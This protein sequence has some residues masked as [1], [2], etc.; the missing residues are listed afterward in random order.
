MRGYAANGLPKDGI[1]IYFYGMCKERTAF[2]GLFIQW[3]VYFQH[4]GA[5]IWELY[6]VDKIRCRNSVELE[7]NLKGSQVYVSFD[8]YSKEGYD[9]QTSDLFDMASPSVY[10]QNYRQMTIIRISRKQ[11]TNNQKKF[12]CRAVK[13]AL[14]T[15]TWKKHDLSQELNGLLF[16]SCDPRAIEI[17]HH[18]LNVALTFPQFLMKFLSPEHASRFA[19]IFRRPGILDHAIS[20]GRSPNPARLLETGP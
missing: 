14:I 7:Q 3:L 10:I 19:T 15:H 13:N 17:N 11:A 16:P 1:G 12:H 6:N 9:S 18:I 8:T 2:S 5:E 20:D 4:D